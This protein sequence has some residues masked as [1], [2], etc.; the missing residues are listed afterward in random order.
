MVAAY[1]AQFDIA[2]Y[3]ISLGSDINARNY[4]GTTV[5]MYAKDGMLNSKDERL[6]NYLLDEGANPYLKD[7]SGKNLFEYIGEDLRIKMIGG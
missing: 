7:Y 2:K 3:L 6:F 1:N 4:N 5:I